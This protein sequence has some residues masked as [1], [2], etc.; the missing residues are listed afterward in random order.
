MPWQHEFCAF[1]KM[2]QGDLFG[3]D[4]KLS[5]GNITSRILPIKIHDLD[6]EDNATIEKEIG[7]ILRAF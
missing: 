6:A 1:N 5:S 2:A 3:R 4:I 7:G